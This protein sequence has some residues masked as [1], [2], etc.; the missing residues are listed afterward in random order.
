MN[1]SYEDYLNGTYKVLKESQK[2]KERY[3]IKFLGREYI[4]YPN[5][6]SPKYFLDSEFFAQNIPINNGDEMLEIGCGTGVIAINSLF[7]GAAHVVAIDINKDAVANTKENAKL[8]KIENKI[9][10]LQGDIYSPLSANDKFDVIFWNVPFGYIE[11]EAKSVL[12]KSIF[13]PHYDSI[14]RFII[15]AK[16]YLK[17][18]GRVIIGFSNVLG[19]AELLQDILKKANFKT[20]LV[21]QIQSVEIHKVTFEIFE[22][23]PI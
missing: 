3:Q 4:V 7:R 17:K 5:V 10:I 18:E 8:N 22:A 12:E 20:K 19:K 11:R 13:D 15:E 16:K 21:A 23:I 9:R 14:S 6:F 1:L 2:E